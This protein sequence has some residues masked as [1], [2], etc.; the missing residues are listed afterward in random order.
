VFENVV[1]KKIFVSKRDGVTGDCRKL[2]IEK[3]ESFYSP[4]DIIKVIRSRSI[5]W[6]RHVARI[7]GKKN[8][9]EVFMG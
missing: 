9:H 6:A 1:L 5:A 3:L 7:G 2:Y 4:P 8:P